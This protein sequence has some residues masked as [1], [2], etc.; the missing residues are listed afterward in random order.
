MAALKLSLLLYAGPMSS[1]NLPPNVT[2]NDNSLAGNLFLATVAAVLLSFAGFQGWLKLFLIGAIFETCRRVDAWGSIIGSF[3]ITVEI[4]EEDD[5]SHG[6]YFPVTPT[7]TAAMPS[8]PG[9]DH[10]LFLQT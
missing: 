6:E 1:C 3:W 9:A 8:S 4:R 5:R 2:T 7:S 10:T